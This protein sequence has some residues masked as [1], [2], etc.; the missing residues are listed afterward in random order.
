MSFGAYHRFSSDTRPNRYDYKCTSN[1]SNLCFLSKCVG[2][3]LVY[4]GDW[5]LG[6]ILSA[7]VT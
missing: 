5:F 7:Y 2:G 6:T 1:R 4:V 3:V